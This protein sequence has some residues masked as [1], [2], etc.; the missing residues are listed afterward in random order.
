MNSDEEGGVGFDDVGN[1]DV[2]GYNR[3]SNFEDPNQYGNEL[4]NDFDLGDDMRSN[5]NDID[6]DML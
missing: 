6:Q 1:N 5:N 2:G 4:K 3:D